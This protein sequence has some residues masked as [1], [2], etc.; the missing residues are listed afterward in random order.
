MSVPLK[1]I[2]WGD[3]QGNIEN[4]TELRGTIGN[5][6]GTAPGRAAIIKTSLVNEGEGRN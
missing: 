4:K 2:C 3:E 6:N 5:G 1:A